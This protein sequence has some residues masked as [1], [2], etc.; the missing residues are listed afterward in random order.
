MEIA[1]F[2]G[3][4]FWRMQ[5]V[6]SRVPGVIST[7]VGFSG[8]YVPNPSYQLVR[9]GTTGHAESIQIAYD[10]RIVSYGRLLEIFF[11]IHD[12]SQLNRQGMDFGPQYRSVIFYHDVNQWQLATSYIRQLKMTRMVPVVT[13]VVPYEAFYPAEEYHQYYEV[14]RQQMTM[15]Y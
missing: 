2:A 15:T 4:C 12:S 9:T 5:T 6:F 1:T 10:P 7:M 8:G 11:A 13:Q 3:G 14:K